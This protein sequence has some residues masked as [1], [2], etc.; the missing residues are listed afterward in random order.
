MPE[1]AVVLATYNEADNL[2]RLVEALESLEIDLQ[3]VVVDDNSPDGTG[4]IAQQLSTRFGN[5]TVANRPAKLGLGSA[6]QSGIAAALN[7]GAQYVITMDADH[8]HDPADVPRLLAAIKTGSADMVQGS[9][10]APG[11]GVE[12]WNGK[13]RLLSRTANLVYHWGAGTPHE[14]TTNFRVFSR[15]AASAVLSRA[16]GNGYEFMPE[17]TLLVLASRLVIREIPITFT[18]RRLGESK[19]DKR[20]VIKGILFCLS[21]IFMYRLRLG[22]FSR[23]KAKDA[24]DDPDSTI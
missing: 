6:L 20:Q 4:L 9:R 5:I 15:R 14:C 21:G 23:P 13:R 10:Y 18:N 17:S 19:L 3:L 7:A 2:G 12:G 22:R 1:L 24:T 8:S 16:K 11:G